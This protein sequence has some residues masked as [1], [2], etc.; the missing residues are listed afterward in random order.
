[1]ARTTH[2]GKTFTVTIVGGGLGGVL[3]AIGLSIRGI[4]VR[5]YE[6]ASCFT[7]T[8]AG[9]GFG[10]NAVRAMVKLDPRIYNA[11][12][13]LKTENGRECK[14]DTWFD[15]RLGQGNVH[16]LIGEPKMGS[17]GGGNVLRASFLME[18]VKLL[19][20]GC[21]TF[22]KVLSSI[23]QRD[24]RVILHFADGASADAD[25]VV[26]CDGIRSKVRQSLLGKGH[27]ASKAVFAGMYLYR[28]VVEMECAIAAVGEDFALSSQVYMGRN[29]D[30]VTYPIEHGS[31]LNVV[32]FQKQK[33][34]M[35]KHTNWVVESSKE[36]MAQ[37]FAGWDSKVQ[38]ILEL[39][40]NPQRHALFDMPPMERYSSGCI[41]LFGDAAHASTSHSGAGAGMA[42]EDAF[43]LSELLSDRR[44][45]SIDGIP[46]AL[47]AYDNVRRPRTQK[48]VQY[49]RESGM[50]FQMR[51]PGIEDD[52]GK[53]KEELKTRQRWIWDIDLDQ[54]LEEAKLELLKSSRV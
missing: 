43:I 9:L 19:P 41:T 29:G 13:A 30:L 18:L 17:M 6:A 16:E 23:D 12:M 2:P 14:K 34:D 33:G 10:P 51:H 48:L 54:H 20:E 40:T 49:S 22:G 38:K 31:L 45:S 32:A 3:I 24:G 36:E 5:I 44:I 4:P 28:G 52:I 35:W 53:I 47:V 27:E 26:G 25:V 46:A 37:D 7:E 50:L 39:L 21:A 15:V 1:M 42:V 11:Y 8:S